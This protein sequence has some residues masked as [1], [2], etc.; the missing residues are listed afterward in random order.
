[1]GPDNRLVLS[2]AL[3][4]L[5]EGF[6][7]TLYERL[8]LALLPVRLL[9]AVLPLSGSPEIRRLYCNMALAHAIVSTTYVTVI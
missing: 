7:F 9:E 6:M 4:L 1:M 8:A 2:L 3:S 5:G